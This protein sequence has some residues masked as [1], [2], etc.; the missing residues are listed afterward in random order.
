MGTA[1]A[2]GETDALAEPLALAEALG[3]AE[4]AV[5]AL[6]EPTAAGSRVT[7]SVLAVAQA[8]GSAAPNASC[9]AVCAARERRGRAYGAAERDGSVASQNGQQGS[10]VRT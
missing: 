7:T 8:N 4:G 6:A 1:L 5:E 2:I 10:S 3:E 9:I